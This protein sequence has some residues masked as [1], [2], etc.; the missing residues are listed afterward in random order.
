[1]S[2]TIKFS[3]ELE[4]SEQ[5]KNIQHMETEIF[6][7]VD[8]YLDLMGITHDDDP[9]YVERVGTVQF[10]QSNEAVNLR[11][12]LATMLGIAQAD[13]MDDKSNVWRSAMITAEG[14]IKLDGT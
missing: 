6:H 10:V 4:V 7:A 11:N 9:A 14:L 1:M 3:V 13:C 5:P 8:H 12:A 2:T